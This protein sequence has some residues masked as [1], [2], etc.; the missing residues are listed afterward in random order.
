MTTPLEPTALPTEG[1]RP[2]LIIAGVA[3]AGTTSLFNYLGQHPEIG[4]SDVKELRYFTPLRYGQPLPPLEDYTRHFAACGDSRFALEAT[5][6]YFYGGRRLAGAMRETC[7]DVRVIVSL[8]SPVDRCWSWFTFVKSRVRIPK[9]MSFEDY[10]DR[11][12][13]LHRAGVDGEVEHQPFWGLGGGCYADWLD[14]WTEELGDRLRLVFFDDLQQDPR[15][16]VTSLCSWLALDDG[17]VSRFD[18]PVENKTVQYRSKRL[19][20]A[21]VTINRHSESFFRR[22]TTAKRRLRAGYYAVNRGAGGTTMR[23]ETRARLEAFYQPYDVRLA[24]QLAALG[25]RRPDSWA[26]HTT[27]A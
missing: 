2:N 12:E 25:L 5:P 1:R 9:E 15:R 22:H 19:Q 3:K 26:S 24:D 18:F 8:R 10:L 23:P 17:P 6:G 16:V 21:A 20:K 11:C 13:E 4:T 27:T 7:P 14:D